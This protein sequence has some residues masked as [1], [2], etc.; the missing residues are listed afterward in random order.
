MWYYLSPRYFARFLPWLLNLYLGN[1]SFNRKAR[2]P[3]TNTNIASQPWKVLSA[4]ASLIDNTFIFLLT[5]LSKSYRAEVTDVSDHFCHFAL[6]LLLRKRPIER[7]KTRKRGFSQ[8]SAERFNSDLSSVDW[9][10]I[11][12]K[13]SNNI[14]YLFSTCS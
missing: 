13:K 5:I 2:V 14:D 3:F 10:N 1:I 9:D 8:F 12:S 11:M 7:K 4:S 6:W